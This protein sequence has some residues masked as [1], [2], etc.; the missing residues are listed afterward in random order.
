[1]DINMKN[2]IVGPDESVSVI[3]FEGARHVE[4]DDSAFWVL[5]DSFPTRGVVMLI[6]THS[7]SQICCFISSGP[8]GPRHSVL[9][10]WRQ[11]LFTWRV[12]SLKRR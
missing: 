5:Q 10:R 2:F 4:G 6:A 12:Y 9:E 7:L 11:A 1:M 3:D 8:L